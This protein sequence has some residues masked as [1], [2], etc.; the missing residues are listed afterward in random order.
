VSTNPRIPRELALAQLYEAAWG[1]DLTPFA[2]Q[3]EEARGFYTLLK[4]VAAGGDGPQFLKGQVVGPVTFA[5]MVK[6]PAGKAIL[7][8][9]ELTQAVSQALARKAVWQ[10]QKF[11]ALGKTAVV[12]FDEPILTGFGS[13]FFTISRE[14]VTVIL[15]ETLEATRQSGPV[16]LGA[17]C[18]GNT[19]WALFLEIPL[20]ILSFDSYGYC[21]SLLLYQKPLKNFLERGGCLAWGL[22]PTGEEV[23]R[24]TVE[25]LWARWQ[26]QVQALAATGVALPQILAQSLLTPSC[27]MG[28]LPPQTAGRVLTM[29]GELSRWGRQWLTEL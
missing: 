17:H 18:C 22:I 14:E 3:E 23:N 24:E 13:A 27:G 16:I 6:D 9:R 4:T 11:S 8:D 19:D 7:Y 28:Y 1:E 26:A 25:S 2:L 20:D 29:L 10:A 21:D 15:M 12:F 5:G